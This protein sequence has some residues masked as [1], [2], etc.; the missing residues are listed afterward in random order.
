[1][2][3]LGTGLAVCL[4]M[5]ALGVS[6]AQSR[7]W[8]V[9]KDGSGDFTV[10]Q[11]A[12]N[13]ASSGDEIEIG[14]GRYTDVTVFS[15]GKVMVWLDGTKSLT[16]VGAGA[17]QTIIGP[18][19]FPNPSPYDDYGIGCT[20]GDVT[21]RV[22]NIRIENQSYRGLS[23]FNSTV[24]LV[25]CVVDHCYLGINI[26]DT[27][28][29]V[30]I[31]D[32][33]FIDGPY[34]ASSY[35]IHSR[36]PH[37][38]VRDVLIEGYIG[39]MNQD[40]TGSTDVVVA[41][42]TFDGQASGLVGL[43]FTLGAGGTVE[44]C[45]FTGW[46]NYGFLFSNAGI[47]VFRDNVVENCQTIGVGMKGCLDFSMT[48][49]IIDQCHT[50]VKVSELCGVQSIHNNHFLRDESAGGYWIRT[51]EWYSGPPVYLDFTD[52]Y[53]GTT[54]PQEI[55]TWILDGYDY[56]ECTMYVDFEP[57]ADGPVTTESA[58]WGGVK[59]LFR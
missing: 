57:M 34:L 38:E 23:L 21:I 33:Q 3:V 52:N 35:A 54:D 22:E 25:A 39:G 7:T 42:C 24:D 49:N 16:F 58:T 18:E 29:N 45:H 26:W 1:M 28:A 55:S 44:R 10:I 12:V 48:G 13:A 6:A 36:S 15:W 37:V 43:Q 50:C 19:V 5:T 40:Y 11:Q 4:L 32:C 9:E 56:P 27:V 30:R 20:Y 2:K 41:D 46:V 53:W 8:R 17:D 14:P 31:L 59:A 47:I 51:S